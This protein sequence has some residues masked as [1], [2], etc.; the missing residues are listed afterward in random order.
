LP[1]A[2]YHR[3]WRLGPG[4]R[5]FA[6]DIKAYRL[7]Y[8]E[9]R[10]AHWTVENALRSGKLVKGPCEVSHDCAGRIEAHHDDYAKPLEVRWLCKRHHKQADLAR[11]SA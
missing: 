6:A 8:P 7:R 5:K 4:R 11:K 10:K 3:A 1:P 9:K 2:E